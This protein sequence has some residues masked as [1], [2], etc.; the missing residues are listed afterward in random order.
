MP[1]MG[2]APRCLVWLAWAGVTAAGAA[3]AQQL[4]LDAAA[5]DNSMRVDVDASAVVNTFDVR[6][7]SITH[8][9][10]NFVSGLQLE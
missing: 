6:F 8:D 1:T 9:I 10:Q 4:V 5:A 7:A 2:T 3:A